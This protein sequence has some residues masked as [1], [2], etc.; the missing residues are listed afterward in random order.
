MD[1]AASVSA[2]PLPSPGPLWEQLWLGLVCTWRSSTFRFLAPSWVHG[3][4]EETEGAGWS[5]FLPTFQSH[6]PCD[7]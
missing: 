5:A 3:A 1:R 4:Q 2:A 6:L 7:V